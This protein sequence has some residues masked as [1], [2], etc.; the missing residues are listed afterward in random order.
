VHRPR[1]NWEKYAKRNDPSSIEGRVYQGLRELITLR[2]ENEVFS[3]NELEIIP[4]DNEHV[5]GFLRRSM[6]KHAVIFANL[7]ENPQSIP[8]RVCEQ[9]SIRTKKIIHDI[10]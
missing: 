2:K 9:Y 8:S 10:L 7:A 1:A 5:L 4:T 3:G 6:G